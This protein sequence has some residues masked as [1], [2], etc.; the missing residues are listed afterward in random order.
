MPELTTEQT[1][2]AL[3]S[4]IDINCKECPMIEGRG[5]AIRLYSQALRTIEKLEAEYNEL[6]ELLQTYKGEN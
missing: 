1:K 2:Q 5:C 4:C 3:K 6:Y